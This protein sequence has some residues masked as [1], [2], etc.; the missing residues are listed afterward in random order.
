MVAGG[1]VKVKSELLSN[2][3]FG[4]NALTFQ[5]LGDWYLY[6][7]I[8]NT[9]HTGS[10]AELSDIAEAVNGVPW[11]PNYDAT[12]MISQLSG[13]P[14]SVLLMP[15]EDCNF[16][17]TYCINSMAYP[18]NRQTKST[19]LSLDVG[20][21][22]VDFLLAQDNVMPVVKFYGGEATL[23][24]KL[25]REIMEYARKKNPNVRFVMTTN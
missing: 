9:I 12:Q 25:V 17:C 14:S 15:T 6:E 4:Q 22:A 1:E 5:F 19:R 11:H 13:K 8:G 18:L 10:I 20:L 3:L 2:V 16:A 7:Q 21:K 23:D 24:W